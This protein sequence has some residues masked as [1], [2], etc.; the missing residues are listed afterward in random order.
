[1]K[2]Y[3][4]AEQLQKEHY[5]SIAS[6]YEAHY[7]DEW[8]QRYRWRFVNEPMLG[9][10]DLRSLEV[11]DAMCG[12]GQTTEYLLHRGARVT[13]LDISQGEIDRFRER[14]PSCRVRCGSI[15]STD[16][17]SECFD[18]VT[19]VGG[20]HHLHPDCPVAIDEIHRILKPGGLFCFY[21]PHRGS[22]PDLARQIWY[23]RDKL[24]AANE[25][26]IDLTML[27]RTFACK[28][29]FQKEE[30]GGSI[31][32]LLVLNS[33]VFR[34]PPSVKRFYSRPLLHLESMIQRMQGK[35]S[36]CWVICRWRKHLLPTHQGSA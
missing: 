15:F 10:V 26:A 27:K 32:Y 7:G 23:R 34:V 16:F 4:E 18:C 21:E 17:P 25:A 8:S 24:F 13:G 1:M 5:D 29:E 20:L 9:D 2:A 30:Y 3:S 22:L 36:S 12:S 11:L 19:V 35:R 31:A 14:F 28:F 6:A 33:M